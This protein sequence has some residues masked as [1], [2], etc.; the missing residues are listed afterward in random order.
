MPISEIAST[1]ELLDLLEE[2]D[3]LRKVNRAIDALV[4]QGKVERIIRNGEPGIR[5]IK[6]EPKQ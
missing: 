5:L 4:K 1:E 6:R 2:L 3:H